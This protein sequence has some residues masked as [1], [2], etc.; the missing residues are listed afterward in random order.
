MLGNCGEWCS[1]WYGPYPATRVEDPY[2]PT[3]G[4]FRVVRGMFRS[5]FKSSCRCATRWCLSPTSLFRRP[6]IGLRLVLNT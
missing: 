6:L 5:R 1:D 2:G 3:S 4:R